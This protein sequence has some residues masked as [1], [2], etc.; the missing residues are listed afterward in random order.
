MIRR[1]ARAWR[2]RRRRGK[3]MRLS[4][5]LARRVIETKGHCPVWYARQTLRAI[6]GTKKENEAT[7]GET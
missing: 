5:D 1:L 3:A 7:D 4:A 2:R 6:E